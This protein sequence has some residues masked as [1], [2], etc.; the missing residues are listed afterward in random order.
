MDA[1]D[2]EA[3]EVVGGTKVRDLHPQRRLR[4]EGGGW[5]RFDQKIKQ[6]FE[7]FTLRFGV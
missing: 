3:A 4:V 2:R 1:A 7:V 6:R 5:D